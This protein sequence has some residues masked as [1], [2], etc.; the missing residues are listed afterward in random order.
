MHLLVEVTEPIVGARSRVGRLLAPVLYVVQD[1]EAALSEDSPCILLK[2]TRADRMVARPSLVVLHGGLGRV[3]AGCRL[4]P[5]I[6]RCEES[7]L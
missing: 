3:L 5:P 2:E 7:V 4:R 1:A 6:Q